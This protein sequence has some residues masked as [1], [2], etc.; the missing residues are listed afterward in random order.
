MFNL[1]LTGKLLISIGTVVIISYIITVSVITRQ[2]TDIANKEALSKMAALSREFA[3]QIRV[4]IENA[5]DTARTLSYSTQNMKKRG[6][7]AKRESILTMMEGILNN[8]PRYLGIWM[9]WEPNAL[10]GLDADFQGK[11]GHTDKG[12][13]IPYWNRV[14]G[15]HLEAC[16]ELSGEWYTKARDTGKEVIMDPFSYEVGGKTVMLVS[17]CVPIMLNGK[18]IGVAGVDF[19][20]DQIAALVADIKPYDTG[21]AALV[22]ASGMMTAHPNKDLIGKSIDKNYPDK[23]L[24]AIKEMKTAHVDFT[25]ETT[26][27]DSILTI[28]SITIGATQTPW[29]ILISAPTHRMLEAVYKMRNISIFIASTFL[30][31]LGVL[32]FFLSRIVFV[33]PINDVIASLN[34]ISQGNGDLTKRLYVR[35]RDELGELSELFNLFIGKL[36]SMIQEI[37]HGVNTLSISSAQLSSISEQMSLESSRTSEKSNTVEAAA[38][39]MTEN[40]T[41][42]SAA[43]EE[44]SINTNTVATAAEEMTATIN[45]IAK[46]AEVARKISKDAVSQVTDSTQKMNV[47]GE[48][49]RSIGKVVETITDISEQVNLL[50]LNATIEAAR[51]GEAGKGFA[52]VANE[53]KEL[54]KQTSEASMDIKEK[55]DNIQDSASGS[56]AGITKISTVINDVNEIISTIATAV[57]EQSSA[58]REIADNINQASCGIQEVNRNVGQS[59]TVADQITRDISEV[60]QSAADI[61]EQSSRVKVSAEELSHLAAALNEMVGRFKV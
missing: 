25:S 37:S 26:G 59:S 45:E 16:V 24:K 60:N 8:N 12:R 40:M 5:L 36:Q 57:E 34:D 46:N 7:L 10:D 44:S 39:E 19:S 51:A 49:A 47:L 11:T 54:A 13:F 52:V 48:A 42:I 3:N 31:L 28:T 53:I 15:V 4:D 58:T 32:I 29:S 20:M 56:L 1:K 9:V 38:E 22:T 27:K 21:Y 14:G 6:S 35:S 17:V 50:S 41:S 18:A 2:A 43:M 61:T 30:L 55:I 33:K 23:I